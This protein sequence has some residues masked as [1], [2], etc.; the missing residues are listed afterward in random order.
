MEN[1]N[2]PENIAAERAAVIAYLRQRADD[3][4]SEIAR[5]VLKMAADAIERGEHVPSDDDD[6]LRLAKE[7]RLFANE[8]A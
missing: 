6:L 7:F 3:V 4:T 5:S 8:D 2:L 1:D